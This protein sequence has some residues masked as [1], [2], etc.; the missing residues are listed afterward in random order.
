MVL[1]G[2]INVGVRLKDSSQPSLNLLHIGVMLAAVCFVHVT[3]LYT[4]VVLAKL[5]HFK[6]ED[7]IA[8]AFGSSQKTLTVGLLV[9]MSLGVSILPMVWYHVSQL[10]IDTL[11]ADRFRAMERNGGDKNGIS[12]KANGGR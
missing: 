12:R 3:M 11:I 5:V 10:F 4:G 6:R 1:L 7:Q 2:A 8:I 9:A